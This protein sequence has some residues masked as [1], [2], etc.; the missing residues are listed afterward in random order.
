MRMGHTRLGQLL[1]VLLIATL[2]WTQPATSQTA[3][4]P[5][6]LTD[7][8]LPTLAPLLQ[9]VTPAV[10]NVSVESRQEINANRSFTDPFFER[11]F[12]LQPGPQRPM[13]RNHVNA[14][15]GVIIDSVKG[16]VLTNSH[17]VEEGERIV[18]TLKDRRQFDAELVGTD[19]ATDIALLQIE[20]D[21]LKA[22]KFG[23]SDRLQIGDYVVAIGNPFGLGQTVTSGIVGAL[24][25]SGLNIEGYEDFIQTD[26]SINPGN[27]GGALI[28]LDGRLVGIN[29]AIIAPSGGNV[30]IGFAVPVNMAQ[31]IA[32][33]LIEHGEVQRGQLG[34]T[35]QDFTLDLGAAL[36][37][38]AASGAVV[39]QV[40]PGSTARA[41][42]VQPGDLIVSVDGRLVTDSSDLRSQIGQKRLGS[43]V[44]LKIIRDGETLELSARLG[45]ISQTRIRPN[46]RGFTRLSGAQLRNLEP[47]DPFYGDLVG[48][49]VAS[50]EDG[51]RA[52]RS[53]LEAGDIILAVNRVAVETVGELRQQLGA[54]NGAIALT[55][56]RG[57]TR[58]FVLIR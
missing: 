54:I 53:G 44:V 8:G 17:V 18:V 27:S 38:D 45:E 30:G 6:F 3:A 35:I 28:T 32:E 40:L 39:T 55:I 58:I 12:D 41:A 57:Q 21:G 23:D 10:V 5:A 33:Q 16:Y 2:A 31:A 19:P 25:R 1:A 14:G 26:A 43:T 47:D 56:Q 22:L 49:V 9:D 50:V 24:G 37:I 20:A 48:V 34:I 29:T 13:F 51:S 7:D 46:D 36:G 4:A 52:A 15:S 42:G 11:F